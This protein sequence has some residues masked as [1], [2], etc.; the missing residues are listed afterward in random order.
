MMVEPT[1][2]ESCPSKVVTPRSASVLSAGLTCTEVK[3]LARRRL[4]WY[5][6]EEKWD[7]RFLE[8]AAH[9]ATWSKDPSAQVGAVLVK[10]RKVVGLGYNGFPRGVLD[11]DTRYADR[12]TKY[13]LVVHA[14]VNAILQAGHAA[15]GCTIYVYPSFG[16]PNICQE[17]AKVAIQAGI[18][19]IVGYA[20]DV[21]DDKV[22][23]WSGSLNVAKTLFEEAGLFTRVY[24]KNA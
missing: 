9:V 2:A 21:E 24:L 11:C 17:C 15:D 20:P 23:R 1:L 7:R 12:P 18:V 3:M 10:D 4:D 8:L 19:G 16:T 13:S 14:E 5:L 6:Q 22:K